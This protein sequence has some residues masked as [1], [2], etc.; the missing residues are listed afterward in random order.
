M[1]VIIGFHLLRGGRCGPTYEAALEPQNQN[2]K[3]NRI[4]TI[5][6][7]KCF[8]KELVN[9]TIFRDLKWSLKC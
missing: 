4:W 5:K 2:K 6:A 3:M 1:P 8:L 9:E 7:Q